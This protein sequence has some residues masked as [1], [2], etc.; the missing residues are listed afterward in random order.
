MPPRDNPELE[1]LLGRPLTGG[2]A[3]RYIEALGSRKD[4]LLILRYNARSRG[5]QPYYRGGE[6]L[7]PD[8]HDPLEAQTPKIGQIFTP[9]DFGN[10]KQL[11]QLVASLYLDYQLGDNYGKDLSATWPFDRLVSEAQPPQ[12]KG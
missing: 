3:F 4:N 10:P 6:G 7:I 9:E 1:R 12:T 2:Y 8:L 11:Q 5:I